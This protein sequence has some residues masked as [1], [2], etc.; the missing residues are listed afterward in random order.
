MRKQLT[1]EQMCRD[2]L[3]QACED[4]LVISSGRQVDGRPGD[5]DPQH[6][7]AGDLAGV[8]NLLADMIENMEPCIKTT[9]AGLIDNDT[10]ET[11]VE[12]DR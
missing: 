9:D 7:S 2:L 3:T 10:S 12:S 11:R 8:A 5:R 1:I 6:R 4:G